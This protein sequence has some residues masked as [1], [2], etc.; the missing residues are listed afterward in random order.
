MEQADEIATGV[1]RGRGK[2]HLGSCWHLWSVQLTGTF[3]GYEYKLTCA[4]VCKPQSWDRTCD[5][6]QQTE[7]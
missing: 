2:Q 3:Q 1:G 4:A 6:L 5:S 7:F